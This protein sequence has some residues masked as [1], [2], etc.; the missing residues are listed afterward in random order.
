MYLEGVSK[1][2]SLLDVGVDLKVVN[3][4]GS[5]YQFGETRLGQGREA[6]K[7]FL[8]ENKPVTAQIEAKIRE[9]VKDGVNEMEVGMEDTAN[10]NKDSESEEK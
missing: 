2:G 4:S 5:W 7:I 10:K 8:K 9:K 1:E 3:K 6:S